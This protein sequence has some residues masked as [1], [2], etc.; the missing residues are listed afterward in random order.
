MHE[1]EKW[2]WSRSIMSDP[3]QPHG[4]Q[5][6][7]LLHPWDFPGRSTGVGCHYLLPGPTACSCHLKCACKGAVFESESFTCGIWQCLQVNGV[8][9]DLNYDTQM[10]SHK[11]ACCRKKILKHWCHKYCECASSRGDAGGLLFPNPEGNRI[12]V[13]LL[14]KIIYEV[15]KWNNNKLFIFDRITQ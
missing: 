5:P 11:I 15:T 14:W 10:V 1:S 9:I 4:L 3:Q 12:F 13:S 7:R 8:T 2:K 6:S